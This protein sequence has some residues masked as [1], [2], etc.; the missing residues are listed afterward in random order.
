MKKILITG[1]NKSIGF[2]TA[3]QLL[4]QGCYVYLGSRDS[5]KGQQAVNQLH[6]EGLTQVEPVL[7]DVDKPDSIQAARQV[8]GQKT[9]VLDGLINNAGIPGK[10][11]QTPLETDVSEFK[12]VFETNFFGAIEVTQA[13]ID[14]LRQSPQ[15]R[16]VNVSSSLGS[17][18]LQTD[19]AWKYYGILPASYVPSKAAL[20]AYTVALAHHLRDTA[21][22]VNAVDPGYPATDLNQHAGTETVST[23]AARV[24]KAVTLGPEGP[25]GQFFSED[26]APDSGFIPW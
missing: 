12:R 3:R 1:A 6:A 23:A 13:F 21:F 22:K 20:N 19:P 7:I 24:V 17:I 14:L 11:P 15:P 25:T 4:Q 9:D 18:T 10:M 2:E 5:Q 26:S 8:L 16:I